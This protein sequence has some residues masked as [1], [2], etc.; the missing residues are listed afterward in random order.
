MAA[1]ASRRTNSSTTAPGP[2]GADP[3][4]QGAEPVRQGLGVLGEVGRGLPGDQPD[5][6]PG[7]CTGW[8]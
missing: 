1:R 5:V 8:R 7:R 2:G 6:L 3:A 4:Q